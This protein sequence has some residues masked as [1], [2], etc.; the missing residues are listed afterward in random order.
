M[1]REDYIQERIDAL[2]Q[3]KQEI[4][5][6][7][8]AYAASKIAE[9]DAALVNIKPRSDV[10]PGNKCM[11]SHL[12]EVKAAYLDG[13]RVDDDLAAIDRHLSMLIPEDPEDT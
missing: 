3:R 6:D 13:S 4:L 9:I 2:E 7:R 8:E 12:N 1:A 10:K 11:C 5:D